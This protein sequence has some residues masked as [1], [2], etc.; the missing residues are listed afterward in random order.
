M[1]L[2]LFVKV[3]YINFFLAKAELL[4]AFYPR[5]ECRGNFKRFIY[6]EVLYIYIKGRIGLPTAGRP[7]RPIGGI[8]QYV[9][10]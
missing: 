10:K 6:L 7:V 2:I 9:V 3:T 1:L 4:G 5:H 8:K